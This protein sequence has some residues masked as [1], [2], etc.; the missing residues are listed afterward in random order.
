[1]LKSPAPKEPEPVGFTRDLDFVVAVGSDEDAERLALYLHGRGYVTHASVEQRVTARLATLRMW[2]PGD[3]TTRVAVDFLFASCGI[4]REICEH[5][6]RVAFL[7]G[8]ELPV[9]S[10]G[11]L[12]AMKLLSVDEERPRDAQDLVNLREVLTD[13][14]LE[15]AR[16]AVVTIVERGSNRGRDLVGQ[17]EEWARRRA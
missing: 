4:E 1:V 8:V 9:A 15:D 3:E 2:S 13:E 6:I 12:V 16:A 14:Q 5:A 10:V 11:H 17:L 7:P